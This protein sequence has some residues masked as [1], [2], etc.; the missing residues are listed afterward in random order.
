MKKAVY[1]IAICTILLTSCQAHRNLHFVKANPQQRIIN[2]ELVMVN[3]SDAQ[4]K[5]NSAELEEHVMIA[6][7][8]STSDDLLVSALKNDPDTLRVGEE[9]EEEVEEAEEMVAE[10]YRAEKLS[11]AAMGTSI[12]A[13]ATFVGGILGIFGLPLFIA[14]LILYILANRSRYNTEKGAKRLKVARVFLT[15]F[16]I[17]LAVTLII[18]LLLFLFL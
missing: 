5:V 3:A 15:I 10:A 1:F 14:A 11:K 9:S 16:G 4:E 12:A 8:V 6:E 2:P 7:T 17:I 13:V 18:I